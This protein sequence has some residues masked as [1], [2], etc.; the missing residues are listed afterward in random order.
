MSVKHRIKIGSMVKTAEGYVPETREVETTPI[1][2]IRLMCIECMGHQ[3]QH[4]EACTAPTCPL[5]PYR[6]GDAHV[7]SEETKRRLS[8]KAK[9]SFFG[10]QVSVSTLP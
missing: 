10:R 2:A 4:I 8:E 6:M 1:K 9:K 7:Y 5:Y 3:P